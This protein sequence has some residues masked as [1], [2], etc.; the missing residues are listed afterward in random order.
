MECVA[1]ASTIPFS[2]ISRSTR[3]ILRFLGSCFLSRSVAEG[4][5]SR[6]VSSR[7]SLKCGHCSKHHCSGFSRAGT[8]SH[9]PRPR[10]GPLLAVQLPTRSAPAPADRAQ[11]RSADSHFEL[12][13]L[14]PVPRPLSES[15]CRRRLLQTL[16]PHLARPGRPGGLFGPVPAASRRRRRR[17]ASPGGGGR[18]GG[19]V[20][21]GR[22]RRLG[23]VPRGLAPLVIFGTAEPAGRL[24]LR[25]RRRLGLGTALYIISWGCLHTSMRV[26]DYI[27]TI[28]YKQISTCL[29]MQ[30]YG[31]RICVCRTV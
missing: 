12:W 1:A 19:S 30:T 3:P 9:L 24:R 22:A 17:T 2:A 20:G 16:N 13:T 29:H 28:S 4:L 27:D 31:F 8:P 25:P 6:L 11:H 23:P 15:P 10:R 18:R 5:S 21:G 14:G 26:S 7:L